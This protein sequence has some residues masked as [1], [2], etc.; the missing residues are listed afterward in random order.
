MSQFARTFALTA[1]AAVAALFV[2][3]ALHAGDDDAE[4]AKLE[5]EALDKAVAKG[6]EL[7]RST[8]LGKKTCA[9]CHENP[10]KPELNLGTRQFSYPK[11]SRKAKAVV[12]MGQ[13][14]N[15][16]LTTKSGAAKEMDLKGTDIVDL[17]A[18]VASLKKK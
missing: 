9:Q 2:G 15:E 16:M 11:Y 13:K 17:E 10:D 3:T 14:I 12:S 5:K 18:Y 4:N 8:S 7:F 6:N 1:A